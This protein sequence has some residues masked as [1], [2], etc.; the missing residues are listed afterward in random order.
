MPARSAIRAAKCLRDQRGALAEG[1][2]QA[3]RGE[4][5]GGPKVLAEL[6]APLR[7]KTEAAKER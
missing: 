4:L 3:D 6:R 2:E 7:E 1:H 5:P